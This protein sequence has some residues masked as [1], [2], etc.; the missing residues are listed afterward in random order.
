MRPGTNAAD[1]PVLDTEGRKTW[2]LNALGRDFVLL[3]F[4]AAPMDTVSVHGVR[5]RVV[6]IGADATCALQ[7]AEGFAA[8]RYDGRPGTV[9]LLRP[10]Q[11][12]AARWRTFDVARIQAAL[13]RCLGH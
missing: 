7:D 12:V 9:Y 3:C 13:S 1:A 2:L 4:G 11:H 5:A 10:D 6:S 8:Q